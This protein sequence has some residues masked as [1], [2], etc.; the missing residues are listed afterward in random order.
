MTAHLE[1][2]VLEPAL[3][4]REL[5]QRVVSLRSGLVALDLEVLHEEIADGVAVRSSFA[6]VRALSFGRLRRR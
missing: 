5:G 1:L 4:A 3:G 2:E 6:A